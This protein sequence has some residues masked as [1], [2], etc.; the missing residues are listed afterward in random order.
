MKLIIALSLL[1]ISFSSV[2]HAKTENW[3]TY[4]SLG[5]AKN[6]NSGKLQNAVDNA[7]DEKD[8]FHLSIAA[9]SWGFYWPLKVGPII[10]G[11]M[12]SSSTDAVVF[13]KRNT[14]EEVDL[15]MAAQYIY[16]YSNML[17][18]NNI[19]EGYFYRGDI[20]IAR[21]LLIMNS[22]K[23]SSSTYGIGG[24]LGVGYSLPVSEESRIVFST[25]YSVKRVKGSINQSLSLTIGGLW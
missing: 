14:N 25:G 6:I 24:L 23:D 5:Y 1:C 13:T 9:D 17:F 22:G 10:S 15:L 8:S 3:Y 7:L 20:G 11:F 16:S 2:V 19:G 18:H 4:W 12:I 21:T